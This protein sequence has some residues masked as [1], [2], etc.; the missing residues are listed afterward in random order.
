MGD[1][2]EI[3]RYSRAFKQKVVGEIERGEINIY[4]AQSVYDIKGSGT[5]QKWI[6]RFGKNHLLRKVVRIEMKDERDKI[7]QLEQEIRALKSALSEE[8]LKNIT[9]ESLIEVAQKHY[10][11]DFKKNFGSKQ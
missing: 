6:K 11:T 2:R 8:H 1:R 10:K 4:Q 9:L 3:L 7:K 5:I